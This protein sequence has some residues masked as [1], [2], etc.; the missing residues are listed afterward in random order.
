MTKHSCAVKMATQLEKLQ[1]VIFNLQISR[2]NI[3]SRD[4]SVFDDCNL[5]NVKLYLTRVFVEPI[6]KSTASKWYST[7]SHLPRKPFVIIVHHKMNLSRITVNIR[8]E[9]YF[10]EN[11][12]ANITVHVSSYDRMTQYNPLTN[13]VRE[14]I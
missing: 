13:V 7:C 6:M 3:M 11:V 1:Y 12:S 9:F 5:N 10:K 8:I 2:R 4:V 14:I